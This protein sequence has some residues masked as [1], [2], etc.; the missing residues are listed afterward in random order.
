[1]ALA[2]YR[3]LLR[4]TRIAFQG[5]L[6]PPFPSPNSCDNILIL[7]DEGDAQVLHA[8]RFQARD[9]FRKNAAMQQGDPALGPAIAH[10]EEVAKILRENVVQGKKVEKDGEER[11]SEFF[12]CFHPL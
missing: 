6:L 8:A 12:L 5:L 7:L 9:A 10:A 11:Y 1:M 4:S 3:H 2:A